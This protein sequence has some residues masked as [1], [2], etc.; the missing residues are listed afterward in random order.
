MAGESSNR[1]AEINQPGLILTTA[2]RRGVRKSSIEIAISERRT[3]DPP[4][5]LRFDEH[6][7]VTIILKVTRIR[8]VTSLLERHPRMVV[9]LRENI[10]GEAASKLNPTGAHGRSYRYLSLLGRTDAASSW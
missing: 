5:L 8:H 4:R 7:H 10:P 3:R 2:G 1:V 6:V 9:R